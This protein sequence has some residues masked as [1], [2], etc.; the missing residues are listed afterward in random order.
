MTELEKSLW[1][2]CSMSVSSPGLHWNLSET[3]FKDQLESARLP[4]LVDA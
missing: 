4:H 2:L 1:L 3:R